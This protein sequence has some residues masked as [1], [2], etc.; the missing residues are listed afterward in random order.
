MTERV[1][2]STGS[3][4]RRRFMIGPLLLIAAC[5]ADVHGWRAGR[6]RRRRVRARQERRRRSRRRAGRLE[7]RLRP[8]SRCDRQGNDDKCIALGAVECAFVSDLEATRSSPPGVRRTTST[9]RAGGT[10]PERAAEG[11]DHQR[12]RGEVHRRG[13]A[14]PLLR[15]RPV[16]PERIGRLRLLVLPDPVGTNADGTFTGIHVGTPSTPGDILI[17]GTFTRVERRRT[18]AC[19]SGSARAA[20]PLPTAPSKDRPEPSATAFRAR[21]TTQGCGTVNN[22]LDPRCLALYAMAGPGGQIPSGGFVEGGINLTDIG[23]AGCFSSFLA[24]TRSSPSVDRD[25]EGLRRSAVS[26]PATQPST[27]T[28]GTSARRRSR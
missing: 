18:S 4:R 25:A 13:G 28:P 15:C 23:L 3:K 12:L 7:Q 19:S 6:T 22:G 16:C 24:E 14:D 9:S 20:T 5:R 17:L 10:R 26:R 11:R 21:R 2:G 1:I 27:T 8:D